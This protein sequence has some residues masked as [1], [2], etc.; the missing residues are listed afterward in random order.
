[1]EEVTTVDGEAQTKSDDPVVIPDTPAEA[2]GA[3]AEADDQEPV[4]PTRYFANI[5]PETPLPQELGTLLWRLREVMDMPVWLL[6]Q[7]NAESPLGN[8]DELLV[9]WIK[10]NKEKLPTCDK[11]AVVV[12]S[13]GGRAVAAYELAR[14]LRRKC[15]GFVAVVPDEAMSAATLLVLGADSIMMGPDSALGPLDAQIWD[16]AAEIYTSVLNEVQA[17]ERLRAYS[18]E[19][20][21]EAMVLLVNRTDKRV[22][23]LLPHVL[24]FVS[25]SMRP[26]L[27]KIDVV[28]YNERARILKVAEE[29]AV[30]LLR[31]KHPEPHRSG[32]HDKAREIATKLVE[33]YPEHGFRIHREEAASLGLEVATLTDEQDM[34]L[35][36]LWSAV[37]DVTAVGLLQEAPPNEE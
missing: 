37:Q 26:L 16:A 29:Y 4:A 19:S 14:L 30:R 7:G 10:L 21:D 25:D 6:L 18:M 32:Y 11:V 34:I 22:D 17:L 2:L 12:N 33:N 8:V 27:E 1:M 20:I 5:F 31:R 28:H 13:P 35:E 15:G 36:E 3:A 24:K 23:S 9:H